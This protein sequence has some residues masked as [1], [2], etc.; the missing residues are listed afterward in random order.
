MSAYDWTPLGRRDNPFPG[1]PGA[2]RT[3]ATGYA[4]V[5]VAIETAGTNLD[6]LT[7]LDDTRSE[8]IDALRDQAIE[9]VS[10]ITVAKGR[11]NTASAALNTYADA[12]YVAQSAAATALNNAAYA[13]GNLGG[14]QAEVDRLQ[15]E[16]QTEFRTQIALPRRSLD[17]GPEQN[18][19]RHRTLSDA[20]DT[21][22]AHRNSVQGNIDNA[23]AQL[24]QAEADHDEAGRAAARKIR[25]SFND[26]LT[27]GFWGQLWQNVTDW[28][29]SVA[30]FFG[31]IAGWLGVIGVLLAIIPGLNKIGLA[32]IAVGKLAGKVAFAAEIL[33]VFTS[34]RNWT[35]LGLGTL[36]MALGNVKKM[37]NAIR[38]INKKR[39][40]GVDGLADNMKRNAENWKDIGGMFDA[41]KNGATVGKEGDSWVRDGTPPPWWNPDIS[42]AVASGR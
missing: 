27:P 36:S 34:E 16:V 12:L 39:N 9:V 24:R 35:R 10:D 14:A 40:A 38:S 32:L 22:Q 15:G 21:A 28:V 5:A 3:A 1:D 20:L 33:L 31:S 37:G 7:C 23:I 42:P 41:G 4:A 18:W 13:Q 17:G 29:R 6:T 11:Y 19:T 25:D 2:V 8:A 26:G 30:D